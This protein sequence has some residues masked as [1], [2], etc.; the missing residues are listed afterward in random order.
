M[1]KKLFLQIKYYVMDIGESS[2][3]GEIISSFEN[4]SNV[5]TSYT[6]IPSSGFNCLFKAQRYGKW[7][8][9]KGLK[10]E[11]QQETIYLELLNKEFELGVQME[12]PNIVHTISKE[13]DPVVGPCIVMEYVDGIT[14]KE[15]LAQRPSQE[16]R[17][18]IVKELLDAM[19]YYHSLQIIHRDLKP[20]NILITRNGQNVKLIDFGLA[21]SD[22][23]GV[24]KQPAGSNK[25][26]A[27]EQVKGNV[28][29]DNRA[30]IYAFGIIL[31]QL[32]PNRYGGVARKCTHQDREKRFQHAEEIWQSMQHRSRRLMLVFACLILLCLVMGLWLFLYQSKEKSETT[33]VTEELINQK[34]SDT[35]TEQQLPIADST[36]IILPLEDFSESSSSKTLTEKNIDNQDDLYFQKEAQRMIDKKLDSMFKPWWDWYSKW[37][38][39]IPDKSLS[40]SELTDAGGEMQFREPLKSGFYKKDQVVSSVIQKIPQCEKMKMQLKSYYEEKF[41]ERQNKIIDTIQPTLEKKSIRKFNEDF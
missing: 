24:L 34:S 30:D 39:T 38:K 32:F 11:H 12:H 3:S 36:E 14:L 27:P 5:F 2:S 10:P 22:Y 8:V 7:F 28:P 16:I 33:P 29:L 17:L 18:K 9:L 41:F 19:S 20:D 23:H 1:K 4:I 35:N 26:A 40:P 13:I 6:E 37:E 15:F 31:R 21:D 25:Y